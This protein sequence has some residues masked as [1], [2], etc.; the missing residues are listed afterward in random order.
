MSNVSDEDVTG[1]EHERRSTQGQRTRKALAGAEQLPEHLN[2]QIMAAALQAARMAQAVQPPT[3]A[4]LPDFVRAT[5]V[6]KDSG[7]SHMP[8]RFN[9]DELQD[10]SFA[11]REFEFGAKVRLSR[12]AFFARKNRE[13]VI[14]AQ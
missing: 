7:G 9:A 10:P 11:G 5:V 4:P 6:A 12:D 2:P 14:I 3:S 8:I 1:D 13:H